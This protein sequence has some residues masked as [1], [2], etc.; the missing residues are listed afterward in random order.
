MI[1]QQNVVES[2]I[3][4][5]LIPSLLELQDDIDDPMKMKMN[6][7]KMMMMMMMIMTMMM[8]MMIYYQ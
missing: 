3:W 5:T 6:K 4:N 2:L 8:K 7:K 1:I